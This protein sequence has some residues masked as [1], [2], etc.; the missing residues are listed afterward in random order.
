MIPQ[1]LGLVAELTALE[2]VELATDEDRAA[3]E[4]L[5]VVGVDP[6]DLGRRR[7]DQLS[8]GQQQRI[9]VA[10]A[11]VGG[12]Q[13][14]LADEP[15]AHQDEEHADLVMGAF[16]NLARSGHGGV[17][18]STHDRRLISQVDRVVELID[19]RLN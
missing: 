17:L 13:L 16:A 19:G 10:R 12:P 5:A 4:A 15:T 3:A 2:N 14:V 9:A 6:D 1:G 8:L 11:L 7:P 18:V